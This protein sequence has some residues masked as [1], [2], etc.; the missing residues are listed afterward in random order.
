MK[1]AI[2]KDQLLERVPLSEY[3]INQMEKN[4]EFPKR[5]PLT[6]RTVAWNLDEIEAWLDE[7]QRNASAAQRDPSLAA[8]FEANPNHRKAAERSAMRMAG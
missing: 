8:K 7:R 3:T 5:F 1:G 2:R 6:N 4:G